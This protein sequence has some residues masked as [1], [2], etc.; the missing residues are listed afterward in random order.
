M[1][2]HVNYRTGRMLRHGGGDARGARRPARIMIWDLAHSA[3]AVPVD[4][5]AAGSS[6]RRRLRRRLRLQVPERRARRAGVC[7][8]A[9]APHRVDGSHRVAAAALGLARPRRAVRVHAGLPAGGRHRAVHLRHAAGA[10]A[11]GARM[12]RRHGAGRGAHG[13]LDGAPPQ[14][15][16]AHRPVHRAGRVAL[17][18]ARA[19]ARHPARRRG[20][21]QPGLLR[22][23]DRRLCR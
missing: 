14:V 4:C 13:G 12:R 2:T 9:S 15:H 5:M 16:G 22:A 23:R 1:L 3:G 21:R 10:V 18:G 11:R 7:V 17:R 8:G 6:R 20:T 19:R